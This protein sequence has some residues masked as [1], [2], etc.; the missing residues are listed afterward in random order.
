[1]QSHDVQEF[2]HNM[3]PRLEKAFDVFTSQLK[4]F[5]DK[6]AHHIPPSPRGS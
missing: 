1:M 4:D 5:I 3:I 2:L 6:G